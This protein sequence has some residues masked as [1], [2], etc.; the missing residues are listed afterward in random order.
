MIDA[1]TMTKFLRSWEIIKH[2]GWKRRLFHNMPDGFTGSDFEKYHDDFLQLNNEQFKEKY[3][4]KFD[5][6]RAKKY[7]IEELL[8]I[9][10]D[11]NIF[12]E[13]LAFCKSVVPDFEN[14]Y[15]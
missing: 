9:T 4:V 10:E 2:S 12:Q 11:Y 15:E 1:K 13:A 6:E 3:I 7:F 8:F 5:D 14:I